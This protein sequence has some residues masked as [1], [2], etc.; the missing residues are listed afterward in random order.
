VLATAWTGAGSSAFSGAFG[1]PLSGP[2]SGPFS[3]IVAL[4]DWDPQLRFFL[5]AVSAL[6]ALSAWR[7][8]R[9]LRD[10]GIVVLGA[11]ARV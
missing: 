1:G 5:A 10:V 3:G 2:F 4:R 8:R 11:A 9:R 7:A 6:L